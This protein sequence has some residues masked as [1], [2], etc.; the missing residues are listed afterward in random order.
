MTQTPD[1]IR[2]NSGLY[3]E[4]WVAHIDLLG[5][6]SLANTKLW[7]QVFNIYSHAIE[8]FKRD[9]FDEHLITRITFSD[10][11]IIYT[12]DASD[13]SYRALDSFC[14][15][16]IIRL[17]Q[18]SQPVRGAM[19]CGKFY[20]DKD[21][22]IYF[23]KA[24]IDA[25]ELSEAQNWIGFT[26]SESAVDRMTVV[27]LPAK[28]RLNYAFWNLPINDR[29]KKKFPEPKFPAFIL[30]L[31]PTPDHVNPIISHLQTMAEDIQCDDIKQKYINTIQFLEKSKREPTD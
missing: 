4:R 14:R 18:S 8:D 22:S 25:Y 5:A 1:R 15:H 10:S 28:E 7:M 17:L 27:D 11:F 21:H 12:A 6:K 24:L 2:I 31:S 13:I 23:G 30:G 16:F 20:A 26:L 29:Y 9:A 3:R 19:A